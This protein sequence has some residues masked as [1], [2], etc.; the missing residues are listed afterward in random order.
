[1]GRP[2]MAGK[3]KYLVTQVGGGR[4]LRRH[5]PGASGGGWSKISTF[6]VV[7]SSFSSLYGA[8]TVVVAGIG[9]HG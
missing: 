3:H 4:R 8:C 5:D 6:V 9:S 1:M 2:E 7:L